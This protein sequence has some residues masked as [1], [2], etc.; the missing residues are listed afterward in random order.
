M[1]LTRAGGCEDALAVQGQQIGGILV[2]K[3]TEEFT[4]AVAELA[5]DD[6]RRKEMG[7]FA[8]AYAL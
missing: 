2:E 7:A 4:D 8:A 5:T 6:A 3:N 1:V